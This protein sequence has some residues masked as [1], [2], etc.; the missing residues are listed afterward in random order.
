MNKS[1]LAKAY[2]YKIYVE[3]AEHDKVKTLK[4]A[5]KLK[6]QYE[7]EGWNVKIIAQYD[8]YI[9]NVGVEL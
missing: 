6:D 2:A 4:R 9:G 8:T 7:A 1:K 3:G 5:I